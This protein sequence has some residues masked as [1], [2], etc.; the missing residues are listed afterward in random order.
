MKHD[1]EPLTA[2]SRETHRQ[3][4]IYARLLLQWNRTINLLSRRDEMELWP[5]HI[6]DSL[7][8]IPLLPTDFEFGLDLGTGG[9][10]PGLVL[11]IATRKHFHL[12]ESDHRKAAFLR[13][14]A[15]ATGC[16][17]T[18]HATRIEDVAIEGA[19]LI[20]ARALAPLSKLLEWATPKLAPDGICLFP[21]G[22]NHASEL[23]AAETQWQMGIESFPSTAAPGAVVLR[24]R[25]IQRVG[26]PTQPIH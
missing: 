12:V 26:P 2:V 23:T 4:E 5:R 1:G 22:R 20:T 19:P 10:F 6:A 3:L 21:K 16:N 7:N 15:R 11:A 14:A 25:D 17:A 9:G 24:I 13:E 8:L 18:V